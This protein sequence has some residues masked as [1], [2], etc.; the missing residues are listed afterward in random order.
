MDADNALESQLIQLLRRMG[1]VSRRTA[2]RDIARYLKQQQQSRISRNVS[3]DGTA[4]LKHQRGKKMFRNMGGLIKTRANER[5]A[6][7]GFYG[8]VGHVASRHQLG[9]TLQ[10]GDWR[11]E[12]PIR[13]LMGLPKKDSQAIVAK[14]LAMP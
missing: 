10:Y 11:F 13:E 14:L 3:P 12:L 1:P 4:M 8:R 9:Q 7:I 2:L 6:E 5:K